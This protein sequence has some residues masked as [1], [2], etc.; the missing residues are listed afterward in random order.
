MEQRL[1]TKMGDPRGGGKGLLKNLQTLNLRLRAVQ[2][3]GVS[4]L[5]WS[6]PLRTDCKCPDIGLSFHYSAHLCFCQSS[7]KET[8]TPSGSDIG[9]ILPPP[10][11]CDESLCGTGDAHYLAAFFDLP[12]VT[13]QVIAAAA[14][15]RPGIPN[16]EAEGNSLYS[17]TISTATYKSTNARPAHTT[18]STRIP[19]R[20]LRDCFVIAFL[21]S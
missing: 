20:F 18:S 7:Y 19:V 5:G 6:Q 15:S 8:F 1:R 16:I 12:I 3:C 21:L 14:N 9:G 4:P 10:V 17:L 13:T 2:Y 11:P